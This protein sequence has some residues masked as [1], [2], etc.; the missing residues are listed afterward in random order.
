MERSEYDKN[1]CHCPCHVYSGTYKTEPCHF[2]GHYDSRGKFKG[3]IIKGHWVKLNI[4]K[5]D[6][7]HS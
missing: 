5:T 6:A 4:N 7:T 1:L 3:N 2:C